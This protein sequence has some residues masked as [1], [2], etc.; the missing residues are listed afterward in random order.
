MT[1]AAEQIR[2][3][4]DDERVRYLAVGATVAV[5]YLAV[6]TGFSLALPGLS[7]LLVLAMAQV[8]IISIAFPLY[9]SVVFRSQGDVRGDLTRFLSV[10][11]GNLVL[12]TLG[13]TL[14][15]AWLHVPQIPAQFVTVAV[16][17]MVS[18][19]AHR[20]FSFRVGR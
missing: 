15:V 9:R 7:F 11:S 13:L 20:V 4:L 16:I 17:S 12:G 19:F 3:L 5:L 10:W 2:R 6:F 1:P 8:V 18:F 14:L